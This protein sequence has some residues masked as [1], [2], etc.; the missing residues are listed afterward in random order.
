MFFQLPIRNLPDEENLTKI[1][2]NLTD[3][4][5]R[6]LTCEHERK[7]R[8]GKR[9]RSSPGIAFVVPALI[10]TKLRTQIVNGDEEHVGPIVLSI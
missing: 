10:T 4:D 3:A 7:P 5:R 2:T 6:M 9:A 8:D 1:L